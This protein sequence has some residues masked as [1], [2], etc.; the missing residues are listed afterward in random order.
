[1]PARP[2]KNVT[3]K[4]IEFPTELASEVEAFAK[5]RGQTFKAVVVAAL[6]RHLDN[7]PP[8]PTPDP[9]LPPVTVTGPATAAEKTPRKGKKK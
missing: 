5:S 9:P 7:P 1:M 4:M 6:R 3:Q 8:P 2:S